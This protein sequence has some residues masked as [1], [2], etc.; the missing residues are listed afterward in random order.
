MKKKRDDGGAT[1]ERVLFFF[2]SKCIRK[3]ERECN[4][5][6]TN[7]NSRKKYIEMRITG[8]YDNLFVELGFYVTEIFEI[9][10]VCS[11]IAIV[12]LGPL[13]ASIGIAFI[14]RAR[15]ILFL[16]LC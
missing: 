12:H 5:N 10:C 4:N 9:K 6:S 13:F 11:C 7:R 16:S 2:G 1:Y 8:M 3:I 14:V 15:C